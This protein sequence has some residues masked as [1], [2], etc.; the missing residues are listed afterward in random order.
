MMMFPLPGRA[1]EMTRRQAVIDEMF[2]R[3]FRGG[4]SDVNE[5]IDRMV[6]RTSRGVLAAFETL[7]KIRFQAPWDR[8]RPLPQTARALSSNGWS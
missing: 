6:A 8:A 4:R 1:D 3:A 2:D 5:G 7:Q